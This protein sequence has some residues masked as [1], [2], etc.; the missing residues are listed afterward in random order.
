[1]LASEPDSR[2]KRRGPM[3]TDGSRCA[4]QGQSRRL[5]PPLAIENEHVTNELRQFS[6]SSSSYY[7]GDAI[8]TSK[9]S[10]LAHF[11]GH[12]VGQLH[13]FAGPQILGA[14]RA[15]QSELAR[16]RWNGCVE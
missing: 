9:M 7:F 5:I 8:R 11:D 2:R 16:S 15:V 14:L 13:L 3:N 1:M 12:A 6:Y 4:W 10:W